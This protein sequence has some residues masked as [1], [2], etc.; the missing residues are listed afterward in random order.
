M[1]QII[2]P[3][4]DIDRTLENLE[5]FMVDKTLNLNYGGGVLGLSGGVDSTLVATVANRA[6]SRYNDSNSN[7]TPLSLKG[8]IMPSSVNNPKD[9]EDGN[10]VGETLGIDYEVKSIE[11]MSE[12]LEETIPELSLS[13]FNSGNARSRSRAQILH[14]L[15][16]LERRLILGTGNRDEDVGIG[17]YTLF[18]DGAIHVS[19]IADLSKRHVRELLMYLEPRF[20][21]IA[22]REPTAGLEEG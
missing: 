13:E 16:G 20:E 3:R 2:L 18:G 21:H 6:Y 19:L 9:E 11:K 10:F 8:V 12:A 17:Y 22:Q 5:N 15:S 1:K 14:T 4:L 7:E